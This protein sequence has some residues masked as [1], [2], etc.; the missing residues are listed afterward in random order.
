MNAA[1]SM[2]GEPSDLLSLRRGP[3]GWFGGV[4]S[5]SRFFCVRCHDLYALRVV[6]ERDIA[7]L[8]QDECSFFRYRDLASLSAVCGESNGG[9]VTR[10]R[11]LQ[12]E[13][14][15]PRWCLECGHSNEDEDEK[16]VC[17]H[18]VSMDRILVVH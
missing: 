9:W 15:R 7:G 14:C 6:L 1:C 8:S 13:R 16:N 4:D 2:C 3:D 17:F 11:E 18:S 12:D 10:A 5:D